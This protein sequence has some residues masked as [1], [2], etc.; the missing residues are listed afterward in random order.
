MV[1]GIMTFVRHRNNYGKRTAFLMQLHV[2]YEDG[3]TDDIVTDESWKGNDSPVVFA[4]IYDGERYD[5]GREIAGWNLPG[6]NES[7]WRPVEEI[8]FDKSVLTAQA[9]RRCV[10]WK[11]SE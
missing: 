8:P 2:E 5:A 10:K 3:S 11:P 1:Q 4:E 7:G 6:L 9:F